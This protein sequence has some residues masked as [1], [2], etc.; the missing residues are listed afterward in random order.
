MK[1]KSLTTIAIIA[2]CAGVV[3]LVRSQALNPEEMLKRRIAERSTGEAKA[4]AHVTEYFDYQCPPCANANKILHDWMEKNPG[5]IYLEVRY[6]PLPSHRFSMKAA[7]HAECAS[8]QKEK[9]WKFHN[10]LFEHQP[11]WVSSDYP[12]LKF[13]TYAQTADLELTRWDACTKDANVE[14]FI[15]EEKAQAEKIG[16]KITPTFFVNGKMVVGTQGLT[17]ELNAIANA[18]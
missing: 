10:E 11:E 1:N 17:E 14:K 6:F 8:R 4:K 5:K 9:F 16:V 12:E 7:V 3:F 2:L 18:K 15:I 13:L